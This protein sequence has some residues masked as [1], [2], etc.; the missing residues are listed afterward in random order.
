MVQH[1]ADDFL[2]AAGRDRHGNFAV[3]GLHN[4]ED[5]VDRFD[6][7][8]QWQISLL[9]LM[10]DRDIS[11]TGSK[12]TLWKTL[13]VSRMAQSWGT[14]FCPSGAAMKMK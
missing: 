12:L 4:F 3:I 11:C 10:G 6:P 2:G 8:Q 7:G 13:P 14:W 5:G 1:Q 9:F